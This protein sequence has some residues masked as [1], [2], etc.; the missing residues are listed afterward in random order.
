MDGIAQDDDIFKADIDYTNDDTTMEITFN[1]FKS[2]LH[3]IQKFVWAVGTSPSLEDIMPFTDSGLTFVEN[4][5]T[6][7]NSM[8]HYNRI[9][10][11]M[12]TNFE[13]LLSHNV[14]IKRS[15]SSRK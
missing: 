9:N 3:G 13:S 14:L 11:Q 1:G 2:T 15:N 7:E 5:D 10:N 8:F 4:F 6:T 12:T